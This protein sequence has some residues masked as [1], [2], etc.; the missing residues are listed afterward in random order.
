MQTVHMYI[1]IL[2]HTQIYKCSL[3]AYLLK[4]FSAEMFFFK[5]LSQSLYSS[6]NCFF[7]GNNL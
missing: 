5:L 6:F 2:I 3:K 7:N 4:Q 1:F